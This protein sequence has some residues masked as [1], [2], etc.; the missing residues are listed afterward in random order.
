VIVLEIAFP[1][2]RF[3]AT[4]WDR[5]V[6]EGEIEWPPSPW[7]L[8]RALI[9]GYAN[10]GGD[11][12]EAL[13]SLLDRL[14]EP[15][16]FILPPAVP[17]HTRH[18][19]PGESLAQTLVLDA[20]VETAR[21]A[22]AYVVWENVELREEQL[23]VLEE[24][25]SG[26][27]YLGRSESWCQ[28]RVVAAPERDEMQICVDL[29][30]RAKEPG[31]CARRLGVAADVRGHGLVQVLSTTTGAMRQQK[32]LQPP[33][34][35]W[36][37]YRF[38]AGFG[39]LPPDET[40]ASHARSSLRAPQ[41]SLRFILEARNRCAPPPVGETLAVAEA[42]RAAA[43][44]C[45][46]SL[47]GTAVPP[48]L[49]GK[50]HERPL[51]GHRHAF[52]LPR[53]LDDDGRIDHVDVWFR[54]GL[55]HETFRAVRAVLKLWD[56][57]LGKDKDFAITYLGAVP[58][59]T[60]RRWRS[61]TPFLLG[62]HPRSTGSEN[63]RARYAPREQL[64]RSLEEQGFPR[65]IVVTEWPRP[66]ALQHARGG[67]T[68]LAGFRCSRKNDRGIGIPLGFTIEF[69]T[70]VQGPIAVGRYAHFGLGQFAPEP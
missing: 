47:T 40:R 61:T 41:N 49:S 60:A 69:E 26:V 51:S 14:A 16:T 58:A 38:P 17:S 52:I 10:A 37:E 50:E 15:P 56:P 35:A 3:H 70:E 6:N 30:S 66:M 39:L 24:A 44:S 42:F 32:K 19:M 1:A 64:S 4:P 68:L 55:V 33:G 29:A 57:R 7:R 13:A 31:P 18:Y 54:E 63:R 65:P 22:H 46:S 59:E 27:T 8:L 12:D 43:M 23:C 36:L 5:A 45:Y 53:D 2:G 21:T 48:E 25:C 67:A 28:V 9:A 34:S 11:D 62:A 20:F